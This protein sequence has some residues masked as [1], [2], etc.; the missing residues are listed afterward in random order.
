[1]EASLPLDIFRRLSLEG[2]IY[3]TEDMPECTWLKMNL[4]V[5]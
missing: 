3:K 4:K 1:M 2:Q 5:I